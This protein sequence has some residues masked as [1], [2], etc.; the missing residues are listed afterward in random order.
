MSHVPALDVTSLDAI[1]IHVHVEKD[2]SGHL[3]LPGEL[4]ESA[5]TYF[6][7][8]LDRP[9]VDETAALYRERRMAAVVFTVDAT[10]SL[11]YAPNAQED[12]LAGASRNADTLIP[13]G[14]VDPWDPGV[15]GRIAELAGQGVRGWKFHPSLQAFN[16]ADER[17]RPMFGALAD[18]GLPLI[19]HTGQTG[20]GAQTPGGYGIRL[21]FSN[22]IHLDDVAAAFPDLQIVMAHPSVPWQ[23][24]AISVATH[25]R[26]VWIDLSGWSPKYFPEPLVRQMNSLLQDRVLFGTD[27]PLLHPDRWMRDFEALELKDSVRPK[28]LKDNAVRL[29]G[30]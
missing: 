19:V 16:P 10:T 2:D 23:E 9:T 8:P 22:P 14:S 1:D 21:G 15:L 5:A 6:R 26:N 24:E 28:I 20:I 12:L 27:Y 4:I 29:L 17:H 3:S 13:F 30:L 11:G 18:L 25:K 7:A